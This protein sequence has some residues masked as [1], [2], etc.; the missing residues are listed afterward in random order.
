LPISN[1][2]ALVPVR[3]QPRNSP[4]IPFLLLGGFIMCFRLTIELFIDFSRICF[5]TQVQ[6]QAA[7]TNKLI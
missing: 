6:G 4:A 3:Q 5:L 1:D 2:K 7:T